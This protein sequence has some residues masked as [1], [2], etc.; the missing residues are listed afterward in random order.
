MA[1]SAAGALP[2]LS[3]TIFKPDG[4]LLIEGGSLFLVFWRFA[5]FPLKSC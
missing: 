5:Q 2:C 3:Q 1:T 4:S